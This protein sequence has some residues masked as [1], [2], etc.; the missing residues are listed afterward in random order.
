M[1]LLEGMHIADLGAGTGYFLP[2]LSRAVGPSGRVLAV[3]YEPAMLRFL[4]KAIRDHGW[5]NVT[6][7]A[8][9]QDHSGLPPN[10]QDRV[11]IVN[12]WHHIPRRG[13]YARHL[14]SRLRNGGSVW[15]IDFRI[16][17]PE[18][19]P[20]VH[21]LP[22]EVVVAELTTGGFVAEIHP[23]RLERQYV[24]VGRRR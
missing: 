9:R 3:D 2:H 21:R 1:N 18:G 15:V 23:L 12:T 5:A 13:E 22:P 19:P 8:A 14:H 11:L 10:S 17:S 7:L 4:K 20:V 16:D 6:T 24:V